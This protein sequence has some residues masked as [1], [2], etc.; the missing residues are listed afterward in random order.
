MAISQIIKAQ[1]IK[2]NSLREKFSLFN[3]GI[4]EMHSKE[5]RHD[6][7]SSLHIVSNIATFPHRASDGSKLSVRHRGT[8]NNNN[9]V[10]TVSNNMK[11]I[12]AGV[13]IDNF[14]ELLSYEFLKF[15]KRYSRNI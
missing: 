6:L 2:S 11:E 8:V 9:N 10:G 7:H 5:A 3:E 12:D 13:S 1:I 4:R 14:S 15:L